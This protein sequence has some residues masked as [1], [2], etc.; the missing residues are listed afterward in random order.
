MKHKLYI[1]FYYCKKQTKLSVKFYFLMPGA[2]SVQRK[3]SVTD[4]KKLITNIKIVKRQACC[5]F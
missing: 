5:V 2:F 1:D 3:R 4:K